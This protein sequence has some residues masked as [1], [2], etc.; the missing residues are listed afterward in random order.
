MRAVEFKAKLRNNRIE[1]PRKFQKQM[2]IMPNKDVRVI[3]LMDD[4]DF[5]VIAQDQFLNG[6]A[7]SDAVYDHY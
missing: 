4:D 3:V 7:K 2:R 1:I 6:Y 5:N